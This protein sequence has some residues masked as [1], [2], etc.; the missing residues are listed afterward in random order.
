[1][2]ATSAE[3]IRAWTGPAILSFGFR[4][5]F[6]MGALWAALAMILW[7]AMVSGLLSLPTRFD[8]VSWHAHEFLFGYLGAV[9]A[10]FLLTAVPNWTGRLPIAG[11]RLGGLCALWLVGRMAIAMSQA[12][13]EVLVAILAL[14]FP[15]TLS[16]LILREIV[17]GKNWR[18]LMVMGM[19]ATFTL[20]DL[21]FLIEA[22]R[23]AYAAQGYGLRL[24]VAAALLMICVVGGRIVPSFT[25]NWLVKT[26][27][28]TRPAS[29]MQRLDKAILLVTVFGLAGWVLW[30]DRSS[31]GIM[32][33]GLSAL[34][35]VRLFRWKGGSTLSEPL[36]WVLHAGYA[37]VPI[38][39]L[40]LGL[41]LLFPE[42]I[43][44][45]ASQHVWMAGALGLMT[46]AVMTRA[47]LGHTGR[48]LHAGPA[49][50]S[51]YL[52]LIGSVA[53]RLVAGAVPDFAMP[54]YNLT[55][56]LWIAAFG[57]FAAVYG[58]MLLGARPAGKR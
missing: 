50:L 11:W 33:I 6:L 36:V 57:G 9:I 29:P 18:N 48:E 19:L 38:G 58:P 8:P 21:T 55:A 28:R 43:S 40:V 3:Q 10:G 16:G 32:L 37:M 2:T 4:P 24:G 35:T 45:A 7:I 27:R 47:T 17:A 52:A 12:M 34:H 44:L 23:G 54:L 56:V 51:I 31:T 15:V 41:G 49:T 25:R 26:D 20:A 42:A 1:M 39:A 30:P 53:V 13:P 22:A 14:A 46:L 5:F